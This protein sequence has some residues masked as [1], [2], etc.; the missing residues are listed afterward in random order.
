MNVLNC[1][2][3]LGTCCSEAEMSGIIVI[4]KETL[5][6]LQII[7]PI[8]LLV[9]AMFQMSKM[10]VYPDDK[11]LLKALYNKFIAATVIFVLPV[12]LNTVIM[13]VNKATGNANYDIDACIKESKANYNLFKG[14]SYIK[15]KGKPQLLITNKEYELGKPSKSSTGSGSG[16]ESGSASG[17]DSSDV[18]K[19][20]KSF[21]GNRYCWGGNDP[22]SCADC[23][24]FVVY[25]LNHCSKPGHKISRAS[26]PGW[27]SNYGAN[28]TRV[29]A[30]NIKP[31]DIVHYPGHYAMLTGNG[32]E[33]VHASNV[34]T[35]IK[36]SPTYTYQSIEGIYRYKHL[37]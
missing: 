5:E 1:N 21:V 29:S 8:V 7:V 23:S 27:T 10:M 30:S 35:G 16:S 14:G 25:V 13:A 6:I 11:K 28:F 3:T 12:I 33:I 36:L 17:G 34:R 20:A 22:H 9:M 2:T 4:V 37:K 24:G 31:G 32:K 15:K 18:V 26:L 19:Y